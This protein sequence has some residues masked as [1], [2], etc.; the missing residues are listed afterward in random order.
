MERIWGRAA[1]APSTE[2]DI[3]AD[4]TV[5]EP[6]DPGVLEVATRGVPAHDD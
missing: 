4:V 5:V 3:P 1:T 6:E 2:D